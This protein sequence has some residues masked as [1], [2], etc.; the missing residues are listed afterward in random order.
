MLVKNAQIFHAPCL[1]DVDLS[2]YIGGQRDNQ[3]N[4][5]PTVDEETR[6]K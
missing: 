1:E 4:S 6:A 2:R 3:D 5:A